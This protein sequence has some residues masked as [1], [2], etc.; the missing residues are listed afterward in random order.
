MQPDPIGLHQLDPA[1]DFNI[2]DLMAGSASGASDFWNLHS[3]GDATK[4]DMPPVPVVPVRQPIRD[5]AAYNNDTECMP[6]NPMAVHDPRTSVGFL[7][8]ELSRMH[9]T[10]AQTRELPFMH[11]RLWASSRMPQTIL[12]AFGA[13]SAYTGRTPENRA[14]VLKL[15]ADAARD[16]HR[17][18]ERQGLGATDKL[19]RVQALVVLA[20]IRVF[21][22]DIGSRAAVER[23][24]GVMINWV[25]ELSALKEE[26][27]GND[28]PQ[29]SMSK[30]RPPTTWEVC[31]DFET[32]R[33][34]TVR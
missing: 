31:H 2:A 11:A 8:Q 5:L 34:Q 21:D 9:A 28:D 6:L 27:E 10:F 3:F 17:E 16:V 33:Y 19:A 22:G 32:P 15:V 30:E 23:E 29:L 24:M 13:A 25:D 12:S 1:L 4:M 14:W 26:L 18:G 20:M 7:T